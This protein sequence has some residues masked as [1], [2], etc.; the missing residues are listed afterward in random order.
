MVMKEANI[1]QIGTPEEILKNPADEYVQDFVIHNL[2]SKIDSL[3]R[4]MG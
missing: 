4:F 2:Q 1:V 3:M